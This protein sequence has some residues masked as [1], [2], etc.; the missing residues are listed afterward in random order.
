METMVIRKE[1]I[2]AGINRSRF[3]RVMK[4]ES[5]SKQS[6]K[7][8]SEQ[9]QVKLLDIKADRLKSALKFYFNRKGIPKAVDVIVDVFIDVF[10]KDNKVNIPKDKVQ[11]LALKVLKAENTDEEVLSILAFFRARAYDLEAIQNDPVLLSKAARLMEKY[12]SSIRAAEGESAVVEEIEKPVTSIEKSVEGKEITYLIVSNERLKR[13]LEWYLR[14]K[15]SEPVVSELVSNLHMLID[16]LS[17]NNEVAIPQPELYKI[18]DIILASHVQGISDATGEVSSL[19]TA[20]GEEAFDIVAIEKNPVLS[21]KM[22]EVLASYQN[23][24]RAAEGG[25][26]AENQTKEDKNQTK[27]DEKQAPAIK[28]TSN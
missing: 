4:L 25:D 28:N 7:P 19:F 3:Q 27:E 17:E 21:Q 20:F 13:L 15:V 23:K 1:K 18:T 10:A 9:I 12:Q 16:T 14:E 5:E 26:D 22:Q 6:I 8:A 11:E 2:P 24:I